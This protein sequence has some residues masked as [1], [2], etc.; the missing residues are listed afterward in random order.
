M[1]TLEIK[2]MNANGVPQASASV[3]AVRMVNTGARCRSTIQGETDWA[4]IVRFERLKSGPY[5]VFVFGPQQ[6]TTSTHVEDG[7]TTSV[8]LTK[9]P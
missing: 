8:T 6:A 3:E 2:V 4:G 5:E 7:K 1:G 9:R